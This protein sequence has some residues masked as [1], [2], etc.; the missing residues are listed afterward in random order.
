MCIF[1]G[2]INILN[3]KKCGIR[4][5]MCFG[6][7]YK[8]AVSLLVLVNIILS[9]DILLQCIPYRLEPPSYKSNFTCCQRIIIIHFIAK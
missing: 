1:K 4:H 2:V 3:F 8:F 9:A 7:Y 6:H 5:V